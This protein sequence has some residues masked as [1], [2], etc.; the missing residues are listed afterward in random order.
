MIFLRQADFAQVARDRGRVP[1]SSRVFL[2]NLNIPYRIYEAVGCDD[3]YIPLQRGFRRSSLAGQNS[4][5]PL[6]VSCPA[7]PF[8]C[9]PAR[10]ELHFRNRE[11]G[12]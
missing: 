9:G 2:T 10:G 11:T 4:A 12:E 7:Y 5:S 3:A 8:I 6:G 1:S